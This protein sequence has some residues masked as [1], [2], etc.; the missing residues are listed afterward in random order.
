[1]LAHGDS[2]DLASRTEL[3]GFQAAIHIAL[4]A[5]LRSAKYEITEQDDGW[6][7][8]TRPFPDAARPLTPATWTAGPGRGITATAASR[9]AM[10]STPTA[11]A[12]SPPTRASVTTAAAGI[13]VWRATAWS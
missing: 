9:A 12:T 6:L 1:M 4:T 3:A 5:L 13:A 2:A 11:W 7:L 10:I 8:V